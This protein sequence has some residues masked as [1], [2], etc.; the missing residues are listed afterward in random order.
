MRLHHRLSIDQR[1]CISYYRK[2]SYLFRAALSSLCATRIPTNYKRWKHPSRRMNRVSNGPL[3]GCHCRSQFLLSLQ[4]TVSIV[5]LSNKQFQ[6]ITKHSSL[7]DRHLV[8]E[9]IGTS[10]RQFLVVMHYSQNNQP[11]QT[12]DR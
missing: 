1:W 8:M 3:V 5:T 9:A 6:E 12:I 10:N 7:N 2:L 11:T 4:V